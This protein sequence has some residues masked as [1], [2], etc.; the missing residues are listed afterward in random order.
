MILLPSAPARASSRSMRPLRLS[1][2]LDVCSRSVVDPA[3]S[4]G[5][6]R[7]AGKAREPDGTIR[8]RPSSGA[9]VDRLHLGD[10]SLAAAAGLRGRGDVGGYLPRS[11][12]APLHRRRGRGGLRRLRRGLD[13]LLGG[14]GGGLGCGSA[15]GTGPPRRTQDDGT[16]GDLDLDLEPVAGADAEQPVEASGKASQR[17][18]WT[19][20]VGIGK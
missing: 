10:S 4:L 8:I 18:S 15:R 5:R 7:M 9:R 13:R 16:V 6:L 12:S 17:S 20:I 14:G 1:A 11:A 3:A 2:P 19:W